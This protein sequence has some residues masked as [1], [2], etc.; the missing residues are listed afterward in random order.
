MLGFIT[1]LAISK[2]NN[3]AYETVSNIGTFIFL[4]GLLG[5]LTPVLQSLTLTTADDTIAFLSSIFV[6][7]H[8]WTYDYEAPSEFILDQNPSNSIVTRPTSL[9][10]VFIAAILLASRL[11]NLSSVYALLFQSL[12]LFGLGPYFRQEIQVYSRTSYEILSIVTTIGMFSMIFY[13]SHTLAFAYFGFIVFVT[14]G[15]PLIF[16]Q[17]YTFKNDVRGPWDIPNVT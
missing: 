15:A 3:W 16:I 11:N 13:I 1:H 10:A 7:C 4:S 9:N 14:F 2:P 6:L 5:F 17:A 8:L 12:F